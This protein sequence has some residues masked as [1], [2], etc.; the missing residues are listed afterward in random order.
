MSYI[1]SSYG[2]QDPLYAQYVFN[3]II[4]NPAY[5]GF[6]KDF[7]AWA[8][9]RMQWTGVDG[10]PE[11]KSLS[12]HAGLIDNR[13]GLGFVLLQDKIGTDNNTQVIASYAYHLFIEGSQ[14]ISFGLRGGISNY[15]LDYNK[16]QIDSTDPKFQSN[17]SELA[18]LIGAGFIYSSDKVF[19]GLSVP[20]I[21]KSSA[22]SN[23]VETTF[24]NQHAYAQAAYIVQ[25][26]PRIKVKPFLLARAVRQAPLNLDIGATLS[27]DD[28]YAIGLF[29]RRL[30]TYGVLAK[31]NMGDAFRLGYIFELPTNK[32]IGVNYATHEFSIGIRM[33]FLKSH[34]LQAVMDF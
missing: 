30:H 24:Y 20:N 26:S 14:K 19:V 4:I 5:G 27:A 11:T 8:S 23:G 1:V 32:S 12:G 10:A 17:V 22:T 31:I 16:L 3:P 33:A 15:R 6:S 9:Y 28:S 7:S 13:M 25:L 2:Q 18:P 29:T 21:L 34:D